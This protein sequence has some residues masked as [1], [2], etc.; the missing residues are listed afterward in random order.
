ME[1]KKVKSLLLQTEC[2]A[3]LLD[4]MGCSEP[5]LT[6]EDG[7]LIDNFFVYLTDR[8]S[9]T[10][11]GP[12]ARIGLNADSGTLAYLVHATQ[13]PFSLPPDRCIRVERPTYSVEEFEEYSK[14]YAQL[15]EFAFKDRCTVDERGSLRK[16]LSALRHIVGPS[17]FGFY[18]ELAPSFFQWVRQEEPSVM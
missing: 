9:N 5:V 16:Y 4:G 11:S 10:A 18:E 6:R 3:L 12:L 17:M 2:G 1:L 7:R 13:K 14:L 8:N 15:R